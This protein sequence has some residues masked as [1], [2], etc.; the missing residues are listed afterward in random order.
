[1]VKPPIAGTPLPATVYFRALVNFTKSID[2]S[3]RLDDVNSEE[4]RDVSEAVVDT[5]ES[6]YYKIP[7]DQVVSVVFIKEIDGY[8]FVELDVGSEGNVDEGQIREVLFSVIE[9]GSIASYVT[10]T[11]GFQFRRLG[12][13]P[14][15]IRACTA[16]EFSCTSGECVPREFVCDRRPDCRD[17]SDEL[18]CD[19]TPHPHECA[20]KEFSCDS[21]QCVHLV[22]RCD[23]HPDCEDASDEDGCEPTVIP[24]RVPG[25]PH[26]P[27]TTRIP[28]TT[29]LLTTR[30]TPVTSASRLVTPKPSLSPE[31]RPCRKDEAVCS[32]KQCIPRDYLCDGERDCRDGSDELNCGTPFPCEPNEF[33][34]RNGHCA[35]KLWRCDGD[36]DCTDG[37]DEFNCPTKGPG[38]TCG[39]DQFVCLSTRTCIPASY[40]CD[41]ETDCADRSDEIGCLPPQVITPPEESIHVAPGTT[42]RFTC[43]AVGV[44]TPMITWRL[45]WG[46]IPSSP[47]VSITSE[48]GRGTLIIKDVKEADQGAYTCEAINARGMVFGI[49]DGVLSLTPGR[50]PCSEGQFHLEATA[51]CLPCFCFGI[52]KTCRE[53]SRH[54]HQIRLRFNAPD[55]FKGVN[56]T[57]PSQPGTPPLSSTQLQIEPGLQEFQLV[58]LSRRFLAHDSFWTLPAQFL[59]NKVDSYG[60]YLRFKVRYGLGRGQ[61][62]PVQKPNVVLV[63]NGQKLLY[64]AQVPTQPSVVNQRQVHFSEENWEKE[65]GAPVSREELLFALQNLEAVMIQTVYDN[66]MASVGLSDVVMDTTTTEVTELG[67]ARGV[68][69]CRCPVG[70]SGLSC[71]RCDAHFKRL[72]GGPYL[73]SCSGCNCNGHSSSCDPFSG[74]CL[75]CQHDTEGP[76][77][78]KCKPG[79]FGD[80]TKGTPTAC[81]PCPCPYTEAPRRFSFSCFLDTDGHATCDA[82]EPGYTGRRCERCAAGYE[83]NPI[84]PGGKCVKLT[85]E[86]PSAQGIDSCDLRGSRRASDGACQCK[87][88]VDGRLCNECATGSFHLSH[89]NPDGCLRC[90]C[91]GVSRQCTSSSW[92]RDQVRLDA[93]REQFSLSNA[94]SSRTVAEGIRLTEGSELTFS[95]FHTLPRDV[96]YWVLPERFKGDKVTSYG[97]DLRYTVTHHTY[98]GFP[99]LRGQPDVLLQGNG[100]FLEHVAET[101]P[102]PGVPTTFT[103]P[104]REQAWRRADGQN[105]TREHLLMALA[106]IDVFM[107]RASYSEQPSESRIS[108]IHMDVAVP[109]PTGLDPALE[110]EDCTCPQ[111][112]RGPSCQDC[113]VGYTR[114]TSGLYLGTCE[115]CDC[116][117]HAA[118]CDAETGDCQDCRDN[119]EG[120]RCER[121]QPGFF[122]DARHGVCRPCP[123]R[124]PPSASQAAQ[125]CFVDADGQP[126]CD[127][128]A[129]GYIGRQCERC[130]PGYVGDPSR[131]QPCTDSGIGCHC[132]PHG[133]I[134]NRCDNGGQCRCKAN[135]EGRACSAC[136]PHHFHL[137]AENAEGCLACF[138]MGVT[139]QCTSSSYHRDVV[140][141]AFLPGNFQG[142]ALVNRQRSTRIQTGFTVEMSPEGPQ[143]SYG[144]FGELG[145][146]TYYWQL[147]ETYLGDKEETYFARMRRA[148]KLNS[149]SLTEEQFRKDVAAGWIP[150]SVAAGSRARRSAQGEGIP[151]RPPQDPSSNLLSTSQHR[152]RVSEAQKHWLHFKG[153]SLL[154]EVTYYWLLPKPFL[155]DKVGSYG[156]RLRYTLSYNAGARGTPLPDADVQLTG[157]DITLV[158]YLPELRPRERKSFEVLFREQFWKRPDGQPATR[159]HLMMALADLDEILIRATFSTDMLSASITGVSMETAVPTY[160]SLARA[161]EVEECRCPPGYQGLSCQDCAAGYTRTGGGLYLGHCTLCEC[162]GHSDACHPETGACSNCLH[163]AAGEFCE[164]CSPGFYGDATAGTPEDCQPCACPLP[165]PENQF[166]RTCESLGGGGYR[167]TACEPGYTGQYCEQ[168]AAGYTGNPNI[169]GQKCVPLGLPEPPPFIVQVHPPRSAVSQGSE[170]TLRCHVSGAPPHYFY[171]SREDGRPVPGTAQRRR[172]GEELFFASIQPSEAGVYV[173]TCRNAQHS[174]AGRAEVIVTEAPSKP[175]TVTVEE[176][177]VQN[178][179][180]GV[181]VTFVCTAKSKSPAY[182]LVWTRQ[183]N[184]KLSSRAMDFNGILTIRNVQ[185]EDAGVYIC[186]GS[187]MFD[188][189]EGVA[190]LYVQAPSKTQMFYG[191]VEVVEGHRPSTPSVHPMATVEP[192]QLSVQ[193]GQPAEFRCIAT[194]S[195]EPTVEWIG[196]PGGVI[197]P[198]AIIQGG[199]LRFPSVKPSDESQYLCRV[200]SSAGQ[201]MARAFLQVHSASVPQV[202]VSPERTEVHEGSTVRLYCRAA[203]SPAATITWEKQGGSLPPQ[204]HAERTDIATLVI[205]SIKA[206]DGGV[207]LCVGRSAAGVGQA[208]IEVVVVRASG[209][210]PTVKIE[211]SSSLVTEGQTLDLNCVVAGHSTASVKWYRRG[212]ALP[213]NHKVYGPLLRILQVSAADSGEYVCRVSNGGGPREASIVVTVQKGHAPSPETPPVTI[214]SPSPSIT[215]GQALDLNCR[216]AGQARPRVTWYKRGGPL[217]ANHKISGFHLRI[218]EATVADSGEYVCRVAEGDSGVVQEASIVVT[219]YSTSQTSGITPPLRIESSSPNVVQGQTLDLNCVTA[220][221]TRATV[222]WYKRGGSL[223]ASHQVS[224]SHLRIPQASTADSGEYVCHLSL[225]SVIR[226][227][228]VIVSS[229]GSSSP[230]R[231]TPSMRIEASSPHVAEGQTLELDCVLARQDQATVTWYKRGGA[232]PASHQVFGSRLRLVKVS[233]AD[234]GEYVCR[235]SYYAAAAQESSVFITVQQ[236]GINSFPAGV[237]PPVRIESSSPS[238][239]EGHTLDLTCIMA[240]PTS[241]ARVTWYKQGGALPA[242]HQ[243]SGFLLRIPQASA[244]D[245]GE[246]VC[247]VTNGTAVHEASLIVTIQGGTGSS[248]SVGVTPPIRIETASASVVEG[249][250]VDLNCLVAGQSQPRVKWYKRGGALPVNAQ[251][252]GSHLRI[253][254]ASASDS[255]QYVCYVNGGDRPLEASVIVSIPSG[256]GSTHHS[257][258]VPP[259]RI[260][261]SSTSLAEGQTLQLNCLVAGQ[262]QPEVTWFKRGGPL[263]ANHQVSGTQLRVPQVSSAHSGEYVCRVSGTAVTQEAALVVTIQDGESPTHPPPLRIESSSP[264][265]VEGHNLDLTCVAPGQPRATFTWYR[266]EGPLPAGHRVSNGHLRLVQLT[267]ADSGEYVCRTTGGAAPQE[268]SLV[269]SVLASATTNPSAASRLQSPIISIDPH[270][271]AV[272]RGADVAFR[273]RIHDGAQ[274]I[275]VSWK[276]PNNQ[277]QDN[278]RISPNGSVVTI[279]NARPQNQGAYRCVASNRFGIANSLV[280]LMVQ[281]PPTVSVVPQGPVRVKVG[282]SI[283]LDCLGAGEPRALVRWS[284]LGA[285][286]K[287]EHQT[288]MP[289]DSRAVLQISSAKLEDAGSYVC[290]AQNT[291]GTAEAQVDVSVESV[292]GKLGAPEIRVNPTQT[293]VA[294]QTAQL[295]CSAT[296]DPT[297]TIH[298]SKLRAPLPWQHRLDNDTL[299]IPRAAQQDSGQYICNATNSAG[300]TEAF[301]MLDVETPPYATVLPD[302]ASLRAGEVV[303]LQCLAHGTPPLR[304]EWTKVNGSLPV[305]TTVR[306]GVLHISPTT[307]H[308]SGTYRCHVSNRVGSAEALARVRVQGPV[309]GPPSVRVIPQS[310]T[311]AVGGTAEFVCSVA[312]DPQARIEW[313]KEGGELPPS[314]TIENGVLRIEKLDRECQGVYVCRVSSPSGQAQ[315]RVSLTIQALPKVMINIRTSVQ[316]VLVGSAVEFECLAFG[317]PKPRV[318]WSKVGGQLRPG[319]LASGGMVK[320][321]RVEQ[322]DAGQYRCTATNNVGAVQSHVILHVQSVPQITAQPEVKEVSAGSM[323]VFPCLASGFPVPDITW[324]KLEGD[325]PQSVRL[326]GN[327]LTIPAARPEDTG[328]YVCTASNRQGKV[329]AFSMLKVR[330]RVVPYFTQNPQSYLALPTM[331]DAYKTFAIEITF[332]PDTPDALMLYSGM[333]VYN[334]Q[335]KNTGTD[336]VS[337]GLVGG[338]PELR[339]DA[340]SGMATIRHPS[341]IKLGEFHTIRLYRNLT[342]GSLVLDNHP[343]VNGTSQGKFQGLDLNEGLYLGGYPNYAAVTKTG[344]SSGFI[345]CVRQLIIQGK[346]VIFKDFDLHAHGVSNC[347]TCQ[348]RPCQNGGVCRDS[349]SSSYVCECRQGFAGSNCEHP[350]ALRCHPEACG[351]DATCINDATGQGYSCRCLLGKYG[352]KC[353]AGAT[354]T[355]PH[356]HGGDAF[357]SYPPLTNIH[358]EL[359]VDIEI[360]PLSPNGLVLFS[361]GDGAPVADFVSLNM[362]NGHLEFR[363]ELG[364]GMAILRSA[365]PLE[366]GQWHRITAERLNK[367]G[368]LQVDDERPVKRSSPGKSQGLNLR[369]AM[370]LGGVDDTVTLPPPANISSHFDGCVGEVSINGKKLDISYSFLESRGISQCVDSSPCDRRPCQHGGKCLLTGEYEFQCLCLDGYKGERCEAREAQC[371]LQHPCLNGGT[372]T[373]VSCICPP[374]FL[375]S[376]CEHEESSHRLNGEWTPEGSGGNDAPGQYGAYFHDGGYVALPRHAFPRSL[377]DAPETIELE[378]RTNSPSGLL[379]WQGVATREAGVEQYVANK[380]EGQSGKAKDFISLGLKDGHL[381]FSYQLGSG[382]ANILSEDP[383]D[384]GE[385]HRVTAIREGRKGFLQVD[386]EE[387]ITGESSGKNVMVNTKGR[388]YLGG[389]PDIQTLTAGKYVSGITGCI[390]NVV[391]VN[392]RPGQQP[393]QPVDLQHHSEAALNIQECPS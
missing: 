343:P 224:G 105:A 255:G 323:V 210:S 326:E 145:Q 354:V 236:G 287:V 341:I 72:P 338:R 91:M 19:P 4:F 10:S 331:K 356:F 121:C 43:V 302:A 377:P 363:Y 156:G 146:Q 113:D 21:G 29:S 31:L 147:P 276:L 139:Q 108:G 131:G 137:S 265:V 375:G 314:H 191:P 68:E 196:G 111:G 123:C 349:E 283:S 125:T 173:C 280:N 387:M 51:R 93:E 372:C 201:H 62:E 28:A 7:G 167:C 102:A 278:V 390:K 309:G 37:S 361:G 188:M 304:Y 281:G 75:N 241:Q 251:I 184:G 325:L 70:Y 301:I 300:F 115:P 47:R 336:F 290:M 321:E 353:M 282:K 253:L 198:Q 116:S 96:Y 107:I 366:L 247:R 357:V 132:D 233:P 97:G 220:G 374:G 140:T 186:T 252:F 348:D 98:P 294:G 36:N 65:S 370:Y 171:W 6:E 179:K 228:S 208:Q 324:T 234:S 26:R 128:C 292:H 103:V 258:V 367:D 315:E 16:D 54:R 313:V 53:T 114:T 183:N 243:V 158:A 177:K 117:G 153:F 215:E 382:E 172:Q 385:W 269:V 165:E 350:Q 79:F 306:D 30:R 340:G 74:H 207:Y 12:A 176:Q 151:Q 240:G 214:E 200:R 393:Q 106:D 316:T 101:S 268:A 244:A 257:G 264:S 182:T 206:A 149:T 2:Y 104:F 305:H 38:D 61:S 389:A 285:R 225:D 320:I 161:L 250:T 222:T 226:E 129:P 35:L 232:L 20:D 213:A 178:V 64:R 386:G 87:P 362:V 163:Q 262:S 3:P 260:E 170:V 15:E 52:T 284:K 185:P 368:T 32:N 84:Q 339:F 168:C 88:N 41:E 219:V 143:L 118:E 18:E 345:G 246:Y 83:G 159:E 164:Q 203:G 90:F 229:A 274:P 346:E 112:Y 308:D 204:S 332:R 205:P 298:W 238:P 94:A 22:Y 180:P 126:T 120:P 299:V 14:P 273:C 23:G 92:S 27:V 77:C 138:C 24:P 295:R 197:S 166:S 271:T 249:Q 162:N 141:S 67:P 337:F 76:Q 384:D 297:P 135:A 127:S 155:G 34:C 223:P 322:A 242:G 194:G 8:I 218:L 289:L 286:Q 192:S 45:N 189:D 360:K 277:L 42:V 333:L 44:P 109:H 364:A 378:V 261:S 71:E 303:Q 342:Q 217:P 307:A 369:T 58:D 48:K 169:R 99:L 239:S 383:V 89:R 13:V 50:G 150:S 1:M 33:K 216:I 195:P 296:G 148:H 267:P 235:V 142:F 291:L 144:R 388:V 231:I 95:S 310:D 202:Q 80:A 175:I 187:N 365:Q 293:V 212:G 9:S 85:D 78:D 380:E 82:C 272:R 266:R 209:V 245:S 199:I 312:G 358:Y 371:R 327:V 160:T 40:Q 122:G 152:L 347:P 270:S 359:R 49:P 311:K 25:A 119:T 381:V 63:G 130:A 254:Q 17:M 134:S 110:V 279:S 66:R 355:T 57:A 334:G 335:K 193:P 344:L 318:T 330:E 376:Y 329:T 328:I 174:N 55:D 86:K 391:L 56:V 69:E 190:T 73:G 351:P 46:H 227:A 211:S 379:L 11:W 136:R 259:V 263:P 124:G 237:T 352:E 248:Y 100:I 256:S 157:N 181:D 154:P 59:G 60:G 230:L 133:S 221:Q 317:D 5:L 275:E 39:P 319:V 373:D 288:L 81:R 392:D